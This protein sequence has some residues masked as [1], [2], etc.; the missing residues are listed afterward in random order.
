VA[1]PPALA[2]DNA[3]ALLLRLI[4][5]LHFGEGLPCQDQ[6]RRERV[7]QAQGRMVARLARPPSLQQIA[8]D[9]SVSPRQLQRDFMA[10]TG[11][12]PIRYLNVVRLSEANSL[13]AET[14]IPIAQIAALLGY[15]S[16]AH[17]STAFRQ[18]YHCS[19][20]EVRA[21]GDKMTR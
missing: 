3:S 14:T 2:L 1:D 8:A 17:F 10:V 6:E 9:L 19:P 7:E 15:T 20:R 18:L 21:A 11:L 16:Q 12:T 13:L 4:G 5:D